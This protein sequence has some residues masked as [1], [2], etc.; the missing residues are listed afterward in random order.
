[1][2]TPLSVANVYI[3]SVV[4]NVKKHEVCQSAALAYVM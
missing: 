1:M 4:K 2:A 3:C